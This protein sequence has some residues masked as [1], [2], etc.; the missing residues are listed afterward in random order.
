MTTLAELEKSYS[1]ALVQHKEATRAESEARNILTDATNRLNKA[2][3]DLTAY[4]RGLQEKAP[5]NTDWHAERNRGTPVS[6]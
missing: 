5:W 1:E 3:K 2:Q 4:M 6:S